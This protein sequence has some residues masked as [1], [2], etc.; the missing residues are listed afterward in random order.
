M[1]NLTDTYYNKGLNIYVTLANSGG[2]GAIQTLDFDGENLTLSDG[3][4]SVKL[5][6]R[7]V[8]TPEAGFS[9]SIEQ[10]EILGL[11]YDG[12]GAIYMELDAVVQALNTLYYAEP[13]PYS[14]PPPGGW[15][16]PPEPV[17]FLLFDTPAE[18]QGVTFELFKSPEELANFWTA[19]IE[20]DTLPE[21]KASIQWRIDRYETIISCP[22]KI[23]SLKD[24]VPPEEP[25]APGPPIPL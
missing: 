10:T 16:D 19:L 12:S 15:P 25:P 18:G 7:K 3:G 14:S 17:D 2:G 8:F 11:P 5:V 13:D 23:T 4:G 1:T 9:G 22:I 24:A 21:V 20:A 6:E